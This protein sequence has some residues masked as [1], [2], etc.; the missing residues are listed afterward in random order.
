VPIGQRKCRKSPLASHFE[1][2]LT[3]AHGWR[4]SGWRQRRNDF[5]S[6]TARAREFRIGKAEVI[7]EDFDWSAG[8]NRIV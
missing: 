8:Q 4:D 3:F 1:N 6:R 5:Q 7:R 2:G